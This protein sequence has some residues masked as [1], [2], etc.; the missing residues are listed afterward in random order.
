MCSSPTH[1]LENLPNMCLY[2]S[3]KKI[4]IFT[5]QS[6]VNALPQHQYLRRVTS[7]CFHRSL[8]DLHLCC[9]LLSQWCTVKHLYSDAMVSAQVHLQRWPCK[10]NRV[11]NVLWLT[12][13]GALSIVR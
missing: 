8:T 7:E 4:H 12:I 11:N 6:H 3:L 1:L 13:F 2:L 9:H 5:S 10:I